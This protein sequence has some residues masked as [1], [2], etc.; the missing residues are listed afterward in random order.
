MVLLEAK[1]PARRRGLAALLAEGGHGLARATEAPW[2]VA[3]VDLAPGED[4]PALASGPLVLLADH[5]APGAEPTVSVL[6]RNASARQVRAAVAAAAAGL[7]V[8]LPDAVAPPA[9]PGFARDEAPGAPLLTPREV[10]IL[11]MVGEGA[12]NKAVARRL[13]I[14]A[15]T[16]KFHLEAVFRK[17][18]VATRAE[19]VARGLRQRLIEL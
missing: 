13:G 14:S 5:A 6:P 2:D 1:D 18:G 16:V 15:H 9:S 7:V 19:A 10:E 12:S 17:L 3:L 8:R 4:A 11:A